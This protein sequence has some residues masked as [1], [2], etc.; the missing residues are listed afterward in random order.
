M[1]TESGEREQELE[2]R[3]EALTREN[4]E[5]KAQLRQERGGEIERLL[6]MLVERVGEVETGGAHRHN[7]VRMH[8]TFTASCSDCIAQFLPI[9]HAPLKV[10]SKL[11]ELVQA[12]DGRGSK[13]PPGAP[14]GKEGER[15]GRRKILK[16]L[17]SA[18]KRV[19]GALAVAWQ[20]G[21]AEESAHDPPS[22]DA[23]QN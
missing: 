16:P 18:R 14:R 6:R 12:S 19:K 3:V 17:Q 10:L 2:R 11:E 4:A 20:R 23:A 13:E 8:T 15:L 1:L 9:G 22:I 21:E 7:E 5:L